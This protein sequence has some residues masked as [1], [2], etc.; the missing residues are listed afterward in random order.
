MVACGVDIL[1]RVFTALA[2]MDRRLKETDSISL[3]LA[4]TEIAS[5]SPM[6]SLLNKVWGSVI[7]LL[8]VDVGFLRSLFSKRRES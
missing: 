2:E 5:V 7:T 8:G 4:T 3:H 6:G 1:E